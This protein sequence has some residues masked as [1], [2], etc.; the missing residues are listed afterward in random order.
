MKQKL[1]GCKKTA[2]STHTTDCT[3]VVGCDCTVGVLWVVTVVVTTAT[4]AN[5]DNG[6]ERIGLKP[7]DG[8]EREADPTKPNTMLM[9]VLMQGKSKKQYFV[10]E[11]VKERPVKSRGQGIRSIIKEA[12]QAN[13]PNSGN[14]YLK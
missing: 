1:S 14:K 2:C 4:T 9:Y 11:S 5:C 6:K 8:R 7:R 10:V 12:K 13:T 3:V